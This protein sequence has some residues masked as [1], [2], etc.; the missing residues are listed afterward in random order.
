MEQKPSQLRK[1]CLPR[2]LLD[3]MAEF[4]EDCKITQLNLTE[5]TF[6]APALKAK[7]LACWSAEKSYLKKM[8]DGREQM[9]EQYSKQHGQPGVPKYVTERE[10]AAAAEIKTLD[11]GIAAQKEII[12]HLDGMLDIMSKFGY[13]VKNC[14]D[15][16]KME[17]S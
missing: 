1:D 15:M 3:L 6:E 4:E 14:V 12:R 10:A 17:A 11:K 2:R 8:E 9:L 16:T 5:K 7:W 13:D